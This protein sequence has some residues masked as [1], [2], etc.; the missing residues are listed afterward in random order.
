MFPFSPSS[1]SHSF[2]YT[3]PLTLTHPLLSFARS[4]HYQQKLKEEG[5]EALQEWTFL[6]RFGYVAARE[7]EDGRLIV[8][9]KDVENMFANS[10]PK[11]ATIDDFVIPFHFHKNLTEYVFTLPILL[12]WM[13]WL[14]IE[15]QQNN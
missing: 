7:D 1:F 8:L 5:V 6:G 15:R 14:S 9:W 10:V 13:D 3:T 4:P 11:Y 12:S 2:F